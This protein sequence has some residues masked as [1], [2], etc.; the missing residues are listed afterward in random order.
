MTF[1]SVRRTT[2]SNAARNEWKFASVPW[3]VMISTNRR[4]QRLEKS[5]LFLTIK[6]RRL[7]VSNSRQNVQSVKRVWIKLA[8]EKSVNGHSFGMSEF[9]SKRCKNLARALESFL[10]DCKPV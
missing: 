3:R 6:P 2:A 1:A 7:T 10:L 5:E 4:R 9:I 8:S